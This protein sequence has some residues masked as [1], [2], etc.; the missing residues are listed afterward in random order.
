MKQSQTKKSKTSD[1]QKKHR[2][3][4]LKIVLSVLL[5]FVLLVSMLPYV[6]SSGPGREFVVNTVNGKMSANVKLDHLTLK[7]FHPIT[8]SGI[9]VSDAAGRE[10][11]RVEKVTLDNGVWNSVTSPMRFGS[12]K[13]DC[14]VWTVYVDEQKTTGEQPATEKKENG[15][16]KDKTRTPQQ[17]QP[18]ESRQKKQPLLEI[19]GKVQLSSG[20]IRLINQQDRTYELTDISGELDINSLN[21]V[22]GKLSLKTTDGGA[23]SGNF[24]ADNLLHNGQIDP[25]RAVIDAAFS[26]DE[27]VNLEAVNRL[28]ANDMPLRGFADLNVKAVYEKGK[29]DA[30]LEASV[31]QL[32]TPDWGEQAVKPIDLFLDGKIKGDLLQLDGN[33]ELSGNPGSIAI[34]INGRHLDRPIK[35]SPDEI[36]TSLLAGGDITLPDVTIEGDGSIDLAK[37]AEAVPGLLKIKKN[38]S[39]E[40]GRINFQQ[41]K[42]TGG[43]APAFASRIELPDLTAR[44]SVGLIAFKPISLEINAVH[45]TRTGIQVQKASVDTAFLHVTADGSPANMSGTINSDLAML[46]RQLQTLLELPVFTLAGSVNGTF[47]MNRKNENQIRISSHLQGE[48]LRYSSG[49]RGVAV[50]DFHLNYEGFIA[51]NGNQVEEIEIANLE[52]SLA[53]AD[54]N[55]DILIEGNGRYGIKDGV[56]RGRLELQQG[57]LRRIGDIMAG[58]GYE[59]MRRLAGDMKASLEVSRSSQ[60]DTVVMNSQGNIRNILLDNKPIHAGRDEVAFNLS[61]MVF[62]PREKNYS[63]HTVTFNSP[64]ADFF[65][66]ELAFDAGN[67]LNLKGRARLNA[68][69]EACTSLAGRWS[70]ND[71]IPRVQGRLQWNGDCRSQENSIELSG[72]GT[73]EQFAIATDQDSIYDP[74]ITLDHQAML[75]LLNEKLTIKTFRFDSESLTLNTAGVIDQLFG[76]GIADIQGRYTTDWDKLTRILHQIAPNT[77][78]MLSIAGT[79]ENAFSVKGPMWAKDVTPAYRKLKAD[80]E[81]GWTSAEIMGVKHQQAIL[82]PV[83]ADAVLTIP[84]TDIAAEGEGMIRL[85]GEV[86]LQDPCNP[87]LR[88]DRRLQMIDNV[89]VKPEVT[90]QMLTRFNPTFADLTLTEGSLFFNVE[91]LE[92]PLGKGKLKEGTGIARLNIPQIRAKPTGILSQLLGYAGEDFNQWYNLNVSAPD[93]RLRNGRIV[94]QDNMVFQFG[95]EF[96]MQF[97]GS[98]GVDQTLDLTVYLPL[99]ADVLKRFGVSQSNEFSK[100]LSDERMAV[101]IT[102]T[103][104]NPQ[105]QIDENIIRNLI[106]KAG[107]LYIRDQARGALRDILGGD[108]KKK[109]NNDKKEEEKPSTEGK[110][111]DSI[112]DLID[113]SKDK[114][115]KKDKK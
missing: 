99:G 5:V 16:K 6:A 78:D 113:K 27:P 75:N 17:K 81:L 23:L 10:I 19:F 28:L 24:K 21:D 34:N 80:L 14:P 30:G 65:G 68:D 45:N 7:W 92:V 61:Q 51:M 13:I 59:D 9:E 110:I 77:R 96:D 100:L 57:R 71:K 26:F 64:V 97:A 1:P 93:I 84:P 47:A 20:K 53:D 90:D 58:L 44:D 46:Q 102:G 62:S 22:K 76:D 31:T 60:E 35:F 41:I 66:E 115:K 40:K 86:D 4:W 101:R 33:V 70:G 67:R 37:L 106:E 42:L 63:I 89:Q 15:Y 8:A 36:M 3:L 103:T 87:V 56:L 112:F 49:E 98:V 50:E 48:K 104:G 25:A 72:K 39:I 29:V 105:T 55:E 11:V 69:L 107:K 109:S 12:V 82:K 88:I 114:D 79:T 43:D 18:T 73:I 95:D 38:L 54:N 52:T 94:Y 32:Q 91:N 111:L 108:K 85:A 2:F 74:K 83:F